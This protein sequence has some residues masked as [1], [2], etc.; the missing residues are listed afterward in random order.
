MPSLPLQIPGSRVKLFIERT[1]LLDVEVEARF[2]QT[3]AEP[4]PEA[5]TET[6]FGFL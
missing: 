2:V 5:E 1:D 6:G 3:L 4:D